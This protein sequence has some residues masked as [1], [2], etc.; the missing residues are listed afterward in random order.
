MLVVFTSKAF[1]D[2]TMFGD[3][4]EHLIKM[5]G[6]SG[7]IPGAVG[8]DDIPAALER[9]KGAVKT[10]DAKPKSDHRT[11]DEDEKEEEPVT[12]SNRAFPLIEMLEAAAEEHASVMW[13]AK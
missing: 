11:D 6:H 7:T 3:V 13:Y 10:E 8:A 9:L 2:I 1:Y 5:M 12:L 4:A